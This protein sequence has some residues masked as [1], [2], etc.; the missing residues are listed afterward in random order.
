MLQENLEERVRLADQTHKYRDAVLDRAVFFLLWH[1]GLR[2]GEVEELRLDDLDLESRK[3]F[4]R[5]GKGVQD[6][7][8][9]LTDTAFRAVQ[10]YLEHRGEGITDHFFMYRNRALRK[11]LVWDRIKAAGKRTGVKVYP[12]RL[13]HTC[14]TQLLN[15]GCRVPSIQRF[16]GHKRLNTTM[17]YAKIH[18]HKVAEDYYD[19]MEHIEKRMSLAAMG[20]VVKAPIREN[21]RLQLLSLI[22][23]LTDSNMKN[24]DRLEVIA[25]MRCLLTQET[26][27]G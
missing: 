13:R 16:L 17:V 7:T 10:T 2:V 8:V 18:D 9:Y 23:E 20:D 19:G 11:D 24:Q 4:V 6:R 21:E 15:A 22:D 12:H 1:G 14:A 27:S 5:R 26:E 3:I 25:Q